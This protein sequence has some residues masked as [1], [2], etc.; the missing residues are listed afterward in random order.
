MVRYRKSLSL[1]VESAGEVDAGDIKTTPLGTVW[2]WATARVTP[3]DSEPTT[4]P[5]PSTFTNALAASV[6]ICSLVPES[7]WITCSSAPFT[8][9]AS[10]TSFTARSTA[11][12][13]GGPYVARSPVA[14]ISV[15]IF[16]A[17]TDGSGARV[18]AGVTVGAGVEVGI[19]GAC[20]A[21][22]AGGTAVGVGSALLHAT[23]SATVAM[24]SRAANTVMRP[25]VGT[26][27]ILLA[28]N[29]IRFLRES[30]S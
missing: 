15:P 11:I 21:V 1:S 22:G 2:D 19:A 16:T 13:I 25:T 9:P 10:L 8:P 3:E 30:E 5:T 26:L 4:P 6:A 24:A 14:S 18:G 12:C 7:R 17:G 29:A 27:R 28:M 23:A 20:V